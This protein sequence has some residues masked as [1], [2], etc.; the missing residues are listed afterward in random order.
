MRVCASDS[1]VEMTLDDG[2]V[3]ISST[4]SGLVNDLESPT[5][6]LVLPLPSQSLVLIQ[7]WSQQARRRA[8]T[9][10]N[11]FSEIQPWLRALERTQ[12]FQLLDAASYLGI[13]LLCD[14]L[15]RLLCE[16]IASKTVAQLRYEC[17]FDANPVGIA[18]PESTLAWYQSI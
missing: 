2:L 13:E 16:W 15:T 3:S 8:E 4:L 14:P 7:Q 1:E 17:G 12:Q 6:V 5:D 11:L 9:R 18:A 10:T